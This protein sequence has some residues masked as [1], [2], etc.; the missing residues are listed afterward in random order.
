MTGSIRQH[1]VSGKEYSFYRQQAQIYTFGIGH[2]PH[3]TMKAFHQDLCSV[4]EAAG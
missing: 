1:T 2:L 4:T 3:S